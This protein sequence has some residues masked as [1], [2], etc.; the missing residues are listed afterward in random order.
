[1]M[2]MMVRRVSESGLWRSWRRG[3]SGNGV[4]MANVV[5]E[6]KSHSRIGAE[7]IWIAW[8]NTHTPQNLSFSYSLNRVR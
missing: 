6:T 4:K 8:T 2:M 3:M 7:Q 5:G 1:M